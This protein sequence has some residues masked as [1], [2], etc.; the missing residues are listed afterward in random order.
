MLRPI[1]LRVK[2]TKV[3]ISIE[4]NIRQASDIL[5]KW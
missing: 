2:E 3:D 5:R 1:L 4:E